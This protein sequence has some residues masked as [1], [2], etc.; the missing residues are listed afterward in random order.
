MTGP[1][2]GYKQPTI[3]QEFKS[4]LTVPKGN[5]DNMAPTS[6]AILFLG[7]RVENL[8]SSLDGSICI[9]GGWTTTLSHVRSTT[10]ALTAKLRD[11]RLDQINSSDIFR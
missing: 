11:S 6:G 2:G 3:K 9:R 7:S 10:A 4:G 8:L 5:L 1:K